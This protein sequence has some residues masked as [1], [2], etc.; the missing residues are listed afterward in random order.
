MRLKK[1]KVFKNT[2]CLRKKN[3]PALPLQV[4]GFEQNQDQCFVAIPILVFDQ[5]FN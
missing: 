3:I 5:N 2:I 4:V 1:I